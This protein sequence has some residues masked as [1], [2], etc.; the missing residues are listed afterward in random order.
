MTCIHNLGMTFIYY[1]EILGKKMESD[2]RTPLPKN[3]LLR[4]SPSTE[5]EAQWD[6]GSYPP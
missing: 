2:P 5:P 6:T 1:L 4:L 3:P